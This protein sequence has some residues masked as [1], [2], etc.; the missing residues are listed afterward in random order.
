MSAVAVS[1]A[2]YEALAQARLDAKAW[3]YYSGG[4]GDERTLHANRAAWEALRL[5]PRVL[6][7]TAGG[8]TRQTLLGRTLAHPV[9][10]APV[11][12]Q[13][14]AHPDVEL[15]TASTGVFD[16]RLSTMPAARAAAA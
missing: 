15:A 16:C 12:H 11:A 7:R 3:A 8:H 14:L 4:A 13:R 2:D 5:Q 1:P 9:L 6:R 10:L